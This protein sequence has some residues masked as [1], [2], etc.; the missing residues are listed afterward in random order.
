MNM[1]RNYNN[2]TSIINTR[3][4]VAMAN[5]NEKSID[6]KGPTAP[7]SLQ[8]PKQHAS[9]IHQLMGMTPEEVNADILSHG[10]DPEIVS[11]SFMLLKRSMGATLVA[12][13]TEFNVVQVCLEPE[14]DETIESLPFYEETVAAGF[15][16]LNSGNAESRGLNMTDM[17]GKLDW[18]KHISVKVNGWSMCDEHIKDGDIV[19][20]DTAAEPKDGDIVLAFLHAYGQVVK[21]LRVHGSDG[22]T[23]ESANPEFKPIVVTDSSSLVIHGVVRGR[24]GRV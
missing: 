2:P 23:L 13:S 17:F 24:A 6:S 22:I 14:S 9:L 20:V 12:N 7:K 4:E 5:H 19:I 10:E 11:E 8:V 3:K 1:A 15:P 18:S 21:R 16:S